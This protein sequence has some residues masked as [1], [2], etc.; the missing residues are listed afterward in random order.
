MVLIKGAMNVVRDRNEVG[1]RVLK[2]GSF[3]EVGG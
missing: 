2:G 3:L 1:D